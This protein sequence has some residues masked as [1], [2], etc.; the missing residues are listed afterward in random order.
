MFYSKG[1]LNECPVVA[2]AKERQVGKKAGQLRD[3]K[4]SRIIMPAV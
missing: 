4:A 2:N 3:G 1:H